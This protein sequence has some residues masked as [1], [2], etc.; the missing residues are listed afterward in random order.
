LSGCIRACHPV[1]RSTARCPRR[2]ARPGTVRRTAST[3]APSRPMRMQSYRT[4]V[5]ASGNP[6]RHLHPVRQHPLHPGQPS[7]PS[8]LQPMPNRLDHA[9]MEVAHLEN[10]VTHRSP[11]RGG[12]RW[13][14]MGAVGVEVRTCH[15]ACEF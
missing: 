2:R 15:S 1:P 3:G 4:I 7:G 11:R 5:D 10:R 8:D 13:C 14:L 6:A 9:I 12:V